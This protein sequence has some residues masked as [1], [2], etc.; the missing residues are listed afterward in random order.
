MDT[1]LFKRTKASVIILGIALTI[2]GLAFFISPAE[3]VLFVVYCCAWA[4]LFAGIATII[5]FFRH[6]P[7]DR[8]IA[9]IIL[10][11][12][13]IIAFVYIICFP[14]LSTVALCVFLGVVIFVTG[15]WDVADAFSLRNV[16]GSNWVLWLVLG[17]LT[18]ILGC[19]TFAAPF[20]M[21]EVIMIVAGISLVFDGVTEIVLGIRM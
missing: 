17:I 1:S 15:L 20:F 3:S 19:L 11:V 14:G 4:F 10:A 2:L 9:N 12:L 8:G 13:E 6:D 16:E 7:A 5:G 18:I 21:A